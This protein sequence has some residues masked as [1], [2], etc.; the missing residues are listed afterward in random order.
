MG[1]ELSMAQDI[2]HQVSWADI[3]ARLRRLPDGK[4][5]GVP[6]GG[7]V[8]AGLSQQPVDT[9]EQADYIIDDIVDSGRTREEWLLRYP[10]KEFLAL[11]DKTA[12][13]AGLGWVVFPWEGTAE[14]DAESVVVRLLEYI[15][16]DVHREGLIDTPKRVVRSWEKLYGGY[17][18]DYKKILQV[19]FIDGACDEMIV[20]KDIG[21]YST[22]E[23]HL[24]PFYGKVA[25]GY[26]PDKKVVGVSKL[27]R[28]VEVFARRL[29]VQERMTSQ[30]A[31][32]IME[33]VKPLGVM[34]VVKGQH[35]CM[36]SRGVEK[37]NSVMTTSAIRGIYKDTEAR[38][39]FLKLAE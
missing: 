18:E 9:P 7:T 23:H 28:V 37:Q 11:Y 32:A 16:E 3:R 4:Y 17:A 14:A 22:C 21:Y 29:Q 19:A 5:Y 12:G 26:V 27:A 34:V 20:L 38:S 30:I 8:V 39:E 25:I 13:D 15:G 36:S 6:R 2:R 1:V 33:V 31:D 35:L 10:D 24:L